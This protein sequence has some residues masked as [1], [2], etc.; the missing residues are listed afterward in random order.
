MLKSYYFPSHYII[1]ANWGE[2]RK[3]YIK[4]L[5]ALQLVAITNSFKKDCSQLYYTLT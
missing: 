4:G 2:V 3:N 5:T 1:I